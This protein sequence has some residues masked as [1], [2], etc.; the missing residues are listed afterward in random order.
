MFGPRLAHR[1]ERRGFGETVHMGEFPAEIP[2]DQFDGGGGRRCA[3]SEQANAARRA[4]ADLGRR[5]DD[6]DEYGRGGTEHRDVF[7]LH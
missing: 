3:R 5:I 4:S 2:L 1:D 6:A 7:F